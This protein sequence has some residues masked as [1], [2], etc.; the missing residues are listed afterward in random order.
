VLGRYSILKLVSVRPVELKV[1]QRYDMDISE[2]QAL[3]N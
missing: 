1:K 2:V 3:S